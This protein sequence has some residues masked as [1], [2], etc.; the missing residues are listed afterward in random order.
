MHENS[1][2]G[3]LIKVKKAATN[4]RGI[5]LWGVGTKQD[6]EDVHAVW[7]VKRVHRMR[8]A[9]ILGQQPD[10]NQ[11]SKQSEDGFT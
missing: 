2:Y 7:G 10:V 11:E 4:G 6:K 9:P 1:R 5:L 8:R 3:G